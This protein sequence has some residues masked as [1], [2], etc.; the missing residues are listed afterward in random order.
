MT[1]ATEATREDLR[2]EYVVR[3]AI[4]TVENRILGALHPFDPEAVERLD[5][6]AEVP[7]GCVRTNGSTS[8]S[9]CSF[10]KTRR[11]ARST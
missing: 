4:Q 8:S 3:E 2:A 10:R 1:A 11:R 7:R 6:V 5:L 9:T